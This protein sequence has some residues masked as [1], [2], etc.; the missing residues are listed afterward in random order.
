MAGTLKLGTADA[1]P[2]QTALTIAPGAVLDLNG[3]DAAVASL[4]NQGTIVDTSCQSA[5]LTIADP[6]GHVVLAGNGPG[7]LQ[8]VANHWLE[9][10]CQAPD[11]CMGGDRTNDGSVAMDDLAD[12]SASWLACD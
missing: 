7:A 2:P 3:F 9:T 4:D 6:P 12:L 10:S 8:T 5:T 1:L 11:W